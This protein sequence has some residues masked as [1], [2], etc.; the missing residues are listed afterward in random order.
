MAIIFTVANRKGGVGKTTLATNLAV[1]LSNKGKTLLVDTDEQGSAY[2]W[3]KHRT[4]QLSAISA[5]D[6]LIDVLEPMNE[7]YDFILIDV[8]GRDSKVFREALL[9]CDKLIVPTQ[10]SLLDLEVIPYLSQR[11]EEAKKDNTNLQTYV[12]INKAP[13]NPKNNEIA[14]AKDYL[15]DYPIFKLTN[16]VIHDRKQFR[17]AIIESLSVTEM[18]SSKAKDEMNAFLI[19]VL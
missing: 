11:V 17:E 9:V 19:E 6:G 5:F 8:A 16:T 2:A 14:Q 15:A 4:H 3:N 12:V 10:A 18:G 1:A 7:V 13:T